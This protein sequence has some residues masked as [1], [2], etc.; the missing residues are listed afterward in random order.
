[1]NK[2]KE[3]TPK[4]KKIINILGLAMIPL[5]AWMI[6]DLNETFRTSEKYG[7]EYVRNGWIEEKTSCNRLSLQITM[8]DGGLF[9][10]HTHIPALQE[11][12]EKM[13]CDNPN[14]EY[15]RDSDYDYDSYNFGTNLQGK[16]IQFVEF[17]EWVKSQE[18]EK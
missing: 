5:V 17:N 15:Y 12:Q 1:M 8:K 4:Q 11:W 2:S 18:K 3:L 10:P 14:S 13:N 9:T 7:G 6:Y 16:E